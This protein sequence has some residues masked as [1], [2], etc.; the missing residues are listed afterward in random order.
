MLKIRL[1]RI[2][3]R[4]EPHYRVVVAEHTT[5]V[6]SNKFVEKVGTFNPK[7]KDTQLNEERIKYWVSVGA[8]PS[9]RVHNMLVKAGIIKGKAINVLPHK[10]PVIDEEKLAKEKE[11]AEAKEAAKKEATEKEEADKLAAEEAAK[12]KT[13]APKKEK[14]EDTPVEE[15]K[16][17]EVKEEKEDK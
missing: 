3:R 17:E 12:A 10:S 15:E 4:N 16:G 14:T 5:G 13:E 8:Q 2:G 9:G 7:T 1:Q 6:K 11:E